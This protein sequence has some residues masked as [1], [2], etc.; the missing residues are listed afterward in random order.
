M[1]LGQQRLVERAGFGGVIRHAERQYGLQLPGLGRAQQLGDEVLGGAAVGGRA[2]AP[3]DPTAAHARSGRHE[4][5]VRHDDGAVLDPEGGT[6]SGDLSQLNMVPDR[7]WAEA[8]RSYAGMT[9]FSTDGFYLDPRHFIVSGSQ[10][11]VP[12]TRGDKRHLA[13]ACQAMLSYVRWA[14][15]V[16]R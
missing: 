14:N 3:L 1:D 10:I 6:V 15:E 9:S 5:H 11:I 2:H 12:N 13:D 7:R 8:F 16:M 4:V